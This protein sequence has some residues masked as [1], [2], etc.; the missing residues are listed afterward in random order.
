MGRGIFDQKGGERMDQAIR[1]TKGQADY[2]GI[3]WVVKAV[4]HE[5]R[6]TIDRIQTK[7]HTVTATDGHRLHEYTL[8]E[9]E[10]FPNGLYY[11]YK[12]GNTVILIK[13]NS[14]KKYPNYEALFPSI[15]PVKTLSNI[16]GTKSMPLSQSFSEIVR[17]VS[18]EQ[19]LNID[20]LKDM[21]SAGDNFEVRIYG[22]NQ[23]YIF[24]NLTKRGLIMAM[25]R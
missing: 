23:V 12:A 3:K 1:V 9:P 13:D 24:Q 21:L 6:G 5:Q 25:R 8:M 2:G 10:Q 16:R 14:E 11:P 18:F 7:D 4:C 17:A 20:F 22:E 19:S 15:D